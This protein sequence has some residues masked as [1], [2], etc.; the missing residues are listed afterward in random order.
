[1]LKC[2]TVRRNASV[3]D[4]SGNDAQQCDVAVREGRIVEIGRSIQCTAEKTIEAEGLS[5]AP[6]FIDVHTH[7]D[8]SVI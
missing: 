1:M 3:L 6:G 2:D 8:T 7:D 4:G 5:L